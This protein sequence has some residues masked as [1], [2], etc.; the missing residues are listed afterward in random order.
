MGD[1]EWWPSIFLFNYETLFSY[2][3]LHAALLRAIQRFLFLLCLAINP[4]YYTFVL[5]FS[6]LLNDQP[7]VRNWSPFLSLFTFYVPLMQGGVED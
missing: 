7:I 6:P 5:C 3:K 4:F 1:G 2:P